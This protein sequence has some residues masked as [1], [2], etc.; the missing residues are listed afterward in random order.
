MI[1]K[2]SFQFPF[3]QE[4]HM[5]FRILQRFGLSVIFQLFKLVIQTRVIIILYKAL[6][7]GWPDTEIVLCLRCGDYGIVIQINP[8]T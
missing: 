3:L 1:S 4:K 6:A 2:N 7:H 8:S 5:C